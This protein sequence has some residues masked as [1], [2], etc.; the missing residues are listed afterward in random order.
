MAA[1]ME[2]VP[3]TVSSPVLV[4]RKDELAAAV[5]VL[6]EAAAG[7]P[8]LLL[9][10]G[11]AGIGKSRLLAEVLAEAGRR[12]LT[13]LSGSCVDLGEGSPSFAPV[14][15]AVRG[16][17]RAVGDEP[18]ERALGAGSDDLL[19][20]L[21]GSHLGLDLTA[22]PAPGR[23]FEAVLQLLEG[24]A[25]ERP[26]LLTIEDAHWAEQST[27]DLLAYL[28]RTLTDAR[29][30]IV[31]TFRT[32]E[33]H[34]RHPLRGLVAELERQ[35][36]VRRIDLRPLQ[37]HEV[38]DQLTAIQGA[39]PGRDLVE[40]IWER[41]EG[42]PFYVE[43]LLIAEEACERV[44]ASVREGTLTRVSVLPE[45]HQNVLRVAAAAG[46]E[47]SDELLAELTNL[48]GDDFDRILRDLIGASLLVLDGDGYRFRHALLQEVV[49]D[50]LLPGERVR[51]HVRIAEH[52]L[53]TGGSSSDAGVA[54]EL[55]HHWSRARR[56]PE[57]LAASVAAGV[58]A[59]A[60]G[61][62]GDAV[63]HYERALELWDSVP[64]APERSELS[65][66][67]LIERAGTAAANV[68]R[69][70]LSNRLY[71][72]AIALAEDDATR[73]RLHQ[74]L[75]RS[76]FVAD[77]PGGL[78]ELELGVALVP[79]EPITAARASVLA[80]YAQGLMLTGRLGEARAASQ[81]AL[82]A[83]LIVGARQVEGHAR[84]TL[85]TVMANLREP[86]G[87]AELELALAIANEVHDPDDIGRAYVNLTH[88]LGEQ[89]S[90]DDLVARAPEALAACHRLGIDRTHGIFVENN[91]VEG[92]VA[93]GRWDD[94][95]AA[96]RSLTAR[97][98]TGHWS[99]FA[100]TALT[101]DRGQLV[102]LRAEL[103]RAGPLPQHDTAV[104]QQL[105]N[106]V[107][108]QIAL[109]IWE[110]RPEAVRDLV[111]DLIHRL[112]PGML[113]WK[114]AT[115]LWRGCW[116]EADRAQLARA[117][118]DDAELDAARATAERWEALLA[119]V[120]ERRPEEERAMPVVGYDGYQLLVMAE[121]RRLD[122]DD[123]AAV[124]L[125]AATRFDELGI[126]FP[127]AYARFR[128]GEAHL[129]SGDRSAAE[130]A[131]EEATRVARSLGAAPLLELIE[132][133][134]ARGRL[135][136]RPAVDADGP[137]GDGLSLSA[138]EREVLAL[139]A[140]GRTNR[141]IA[142]ALYISPK[143]A[144][145]HVSNILAKLGVSGRVEAAAVAHRVGLTT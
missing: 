42:N 78:E 19:A 5:A 49:Y 112:P 13:I 126:V 82:D 108:A 117:R 125:T 118:R 63:A 115:T 123:D 101:A 130:A 66:L 140:E 132:Q 23:V 110:G 62:P 30:A 95:A 31:V 105:A 44:P 73:G 122:G 1:M 6:D 143:T 29:V 92:L 22:Q 70:E 67:D 57:A 138:R 15:D 83:A 79:A 129:R 65:K 114:V 17:R 75:G 53:A 10:G 100:I 94:A 36:R 64:D 128:A 124:W 9:I 48:P 77:Q 133:L 25:D 120:A 45:G 98:P 68:G 109:A 58:A 99:Y 72:S 102:E 34:R 84:N 113:G 50:E 35:P 131:L 69:F 96:Q 134:A 11:E 21:P 55:A 43:E 145:V 87:L 80:G 12:E 26:V 104:L 37:R 97:L 2:A 8:R 90:W 60:V 89:G 121:R 40:S 111:A 74:R 20:L 28:S 51:L 27:R 16:L 47:V 59:E 46:R 32:D 127:A 135:G 52:L 106:A 141:E 103:E 3:R 136:A 119:T 61:A 142:D 14:A 4:G 137:V 54:P 86:G 76:L 38:V 81:A 39:P 91:F 33:L 24:L 107:E 93:M 71:R 7:D 41:G 56:A 116:A 144:S 85:G 18:V 88:V 139:V